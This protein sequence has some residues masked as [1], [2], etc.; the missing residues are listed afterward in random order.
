MNLCA[1]FIQSLSKL[2]T[3]MSASNILKFGANFSVCYVT[4]NEKEYVR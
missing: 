4:L 3:S 1:N 2:S